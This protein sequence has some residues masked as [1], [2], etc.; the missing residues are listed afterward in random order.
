MGA[1][2]GLV[3]VV[4]VVAV[5]TVVVLSRE[6]EAPVRPGMFTPSAIL[7]EKAMQRI[8][9]T[10]P[11]PD[12][13]EPQPTPG[14]GEDLVPLDVVRI[15]GSCMDIVTEYVPRSRVAARQDEL[16]SDP[17]V[18]AVSL[19]PTPQ[20]TDVADD[21][22]YGQWPL[23][24]LGASIEP[25]DL[26]W[27]HA[28]G[29]VVAVIDTGIDRAHLE[30]AG[31]V[32]ARRTFA[33][34][35]G[36][37][38][39]PGGHGTLSA[40]IIGARI[41]DGGIVGVAPGTQILD[42]PIR[43][44]GGGELLNETGPSMAAGLM[45]AINHGAQVAN[46]SAGMYTPGTTP[47]PN[48]NGFLD[49]VTGYLD[50][51]NWKALASAATKA[52]ERDVVV[53]STTVNN[54]PGATP[55]LIYSPAYFPTVLGVGAVDRTGGLASFSSR[56]EVMD[57]VA[58]GDDIFST[59]P[60]GGYVVQDGTSFAAPH[61]TAAAAIL[62]WAA[63]DRSAAEIR[64][65][66]IGTAEPLEGEPFGSGSGLLNIPDALRLVDRPSDEP[67]PTGDSL[68][69]RTQSA[70]VSGRTLYVVDGHAARPIW[71]LPVNQTA[72]LEQVEDSVD[73]DWSADHTRGV[74]TDRDTVFTWEGTGKPVA[75]QCPD[76]DIAY[77][78]GTPSPTDDVIVTFTGNG[79]IQRRD[80]KTLH[81]IST[82]RLQLGT[83]DLWASLDGDLNGKLLIS[84]P[85]GNSTA[86]EGPDTLWLIDPSN[87]SVHAKYQSPNNG[88]IHHVAVSADGH[89]LALV[90][91]RH[92]G[93]CR[94]TAHV[95][96]LD[97]NTLK[98]LRHP[99]PVR[100]DLDLL[101]VDDLFYNGPYVYAVMSG[102]N[103]ANDCSEVMV[104]GL[105]RLS[106][107]GWTQIDPGALY[108]A[109][110]VEGLSTTPA[111]GQLIVTHDKRILFT[112]Q[113][114]GQNNQQQLNAN[115]R[116]SGG[117]PLWSTPTRSEIRLGRE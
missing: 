12:C 37:D 109:R 18:L 90:S 100:A 102:R 94:S 98:L 34:D 103:T 99:D 71:T 105:W 112:T 60:G 24:M 13:S 22:R 11:S 66:L 48:S 2:V 93:S 8:A 23:T 81:L 32:T 115:V 35:P 101:R 39:L 6:R 83:P 1:V 27:P 96:L 114:T 19:T 86:G 82:V 58:P 36:G 55:D 77:V 106:S 67:P 61:V 20:L 28:D 4:A 89:Q 59:K 31:V 69:D 49:V 72:I 53:V 108:A 3:L 116:T 117:G 78:D 56:T 41:G 7:G 45:W 57:I 113:S 110:P 104:P 43:V 52:E 33:D 21:K 17:E 29:V 88:K 26:P 75:T 84:T 68:A 91:A 80:P 14:R 42:V 107:R 38:A 5:A 95:Y 76:C 70:F 74:A 111:A 64:Q 9:D 92:N 30:L 16:S 15:S 25:K 40:G 97:A 54:L 44:Y 62:R 63:P 47:S 51:E 87:G 46:I 50:M 79:T 65:A 73:V 85:E 10:T